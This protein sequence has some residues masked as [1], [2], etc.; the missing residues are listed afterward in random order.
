MYLVIEDID[1]DL[2]I[3]FLIEEYFNDGTIEFHTIEETFEIITQLNSI[4]KF[5]KWYSSNHNCDVNAIIFSCDSETNII[6]IN[7]LCNKFAC[8]FNL[9]SR[10]L[11]LINTNIITENNDYY[12]K[13]KIQAFDI[14]EILD[15]NTLIN[16]PQLNSID[17]INNNMDYI[18]LDN[19]THHIAQTNIN[20]V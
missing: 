8:N 1:A 14:K 13:L 19:N 20:D 11:I 3:Q 9:S 18:S 15:V 5:F 6:L 17:N 2:R 4:N 12:E 7:E 16:T 10:Y